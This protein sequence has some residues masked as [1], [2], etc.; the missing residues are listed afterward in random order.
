MTVR[1][2]M[3]QTRAG[4]PYWYFTVP[5]ICFTVQDDEPVLAR[6]SRPDR[7]HL[8]NGLVVTE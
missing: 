3:T 4:R 5:I 8:R 1:R 7:P 2:S 6:L